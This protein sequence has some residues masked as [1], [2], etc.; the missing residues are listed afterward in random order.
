MTTELYLPA[1]VG[2]D[3]VD[4]LSPTQ[5]AALQRG[6]AKIVALGAQVGISPDQMVA[7]LNAGLTVCELLEYLVAR[8]GEVA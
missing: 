7:M 8:S 3:P 6:V 4:S 2:N 1:G 5:T